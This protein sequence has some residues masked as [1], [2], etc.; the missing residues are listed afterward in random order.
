MT[1]FVP[2]NFGQPLLTMELNLRLFLILVIFIIPIANADEKSEI[3]FVSGETANECVSY[4]SQR[5]NEDIRDTINNMIIASEYLE[6]SLSDSLKVVGN[7]EEIISQIYENV[8]I[9]S[10]PTSLGP[11]VPR[12]SL[13]SEKF[14]LVLPNKIVFETKSHNVNIS[15]K[16]VLSGNRYLIWVVDE[17]LDATYRSYYPAILL[18]EG[19]QINVLPFYESGF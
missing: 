15:I 16:G 13:L 17:I 1:S 3:T 11:S 6:C 18:I 8:R 4:N 19:E 2:R 5:A 14:E 9:R 12:N 7:P 10:L